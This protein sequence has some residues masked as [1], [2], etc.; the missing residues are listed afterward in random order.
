MAIAPFVKGIGAF[1][2]LIASVVLIAA[3][4]A[5]WYSFES[6]ATQPHSPED[7]VTQSSYPGLASANGTVRYTCVVLAPCPSQTSYTNAR[8]NNTGE[9]AEA[10][11]FILIGGFVLGI[12]A[13]AAGFFS[14]RNPRLTHPAIEM[15]VFALV[16]AVA[17]PTLFAVALPGAVAKDVPT[18]ERPSAT[19]T[20]PWSSFFGS[21]ATSLPG[22][23]TQTLTWGPS[24]G[25]YLAIGAFILLLIGAI[26]L[27]R[28]RRP[29]PSL[30]SVPS[31]VKS[32]APTE[33]T[34]AAS[35]TTAQI[36]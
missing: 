32:P 21:S 2:L 6:A 3:L 19:S 10:G 5:P 12:V 20:G 8:E 33:P 18:S 29:L 26:L 17:A 13:S 4:V 25:W 16:L 35:A 30:V 14:R 31:P 28:S 7:S 9:I 34:P 1:C 24:I 36:R 22:G 11:F 27:Y 15:A 23:V